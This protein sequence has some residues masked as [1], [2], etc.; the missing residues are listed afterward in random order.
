[1][2]EEIKF[3]HLS[4]KEEISK[5]RTALFKEINGDIFYSLSLWLNEIKM[6]FWKKPIGYED[7]FKLVQW[8]WLSSKPYEEMDCVL[9]ILGTE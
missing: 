6:A 5:W 3:V 2:S 8:Q 9:N 7:T 4:S 1:M